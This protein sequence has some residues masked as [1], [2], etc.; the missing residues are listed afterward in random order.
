MSTLGEILSQLHDEDQV[1]AILADAGDVKS[2]ASLHDL[3]RRSGQT[4]CEWAIDAV[5]DFTEKAD[6]EAWVKLIGRIQNADSP[7]SACL[8][9][10]I[11]WS[12]ER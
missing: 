5:H 7:G 2:I 1:F 6:N 4:A 8:S 11:A 9:E 3:A 10:I 12:L